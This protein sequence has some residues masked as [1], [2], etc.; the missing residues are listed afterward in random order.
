MENDYIELYAVKQPELIEVKTK[1]RFVPKR[2]TVIYE[3][4]TLKNEN[5]SKESKQD[6]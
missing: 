3:L 5:I 1:Q 4:E 6:E 2:I